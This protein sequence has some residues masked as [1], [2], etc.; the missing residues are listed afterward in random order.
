MNT[1]IGMMKLADN[2]VVTQISFFFIF[3]FFLIILGLHAWRVEVPR[4][5]VKSE[6]KLPAH[7]TVMQ[8]QIQALSET[9]TIA[10]GNEGS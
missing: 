7:T 5:R 8:R 4:L 2:I 3:F 10:H 6:L 1:P 9:Y